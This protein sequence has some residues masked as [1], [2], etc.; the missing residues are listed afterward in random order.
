MDRIRTDSYENLP[1][2]QREYLSVY[3][4]CFSKKLCEHAI[5]ELK[6]KNGNKIEPLTKEYIDNLLNSNRLTL[7]NDNGY[8]S[9]YIANVAKAKLF[10][11]SIVSEQHLAQYIKDIIDDKCNYA[12][13][14]L[15][16]YYA[17]I[18][19]SGKALIWEDFI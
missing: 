10:G 8:D 5:S 16:R 3:G 6:D 17:D 12:G 1:S 4:W 18:I 14:A 11:S 19:G 13:F 2:G 7:E 9:V 15:T